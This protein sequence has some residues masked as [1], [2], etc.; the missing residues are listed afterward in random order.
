MGWV[1][2]ILFGS[3][4][5]L[6][7]L[8]FFKTAQSK[9]NLEQQIDQVTFSLKN[10]I[11]ELQQQIRNLELD[12]EIT[13][14]QSG[15]LDVSSKERQMLREMLDLHKRGYSFDSIALK[16][17][18]TPNEAERMLLPYLSKKAERSMVAQ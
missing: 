2:A 5:V 13:A 17:Q 10:E 16:Q 15:A 1:I 6:L 7:I 4:V 14:Q 8:S 3:A 9:S 12:A 18:L 11:H